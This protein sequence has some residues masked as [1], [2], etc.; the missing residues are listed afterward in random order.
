MSAEHEFKGI[1]YQSQRY[2]R[3]QTLMHNVNEESLREKHR[4]Q[5]CRKASGVNGVTKDV[6]FGRR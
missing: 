2:A 3:V 6:M 5:E 4:K 1:K